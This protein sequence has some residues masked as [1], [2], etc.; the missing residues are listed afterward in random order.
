MKKSVGLPRMHKE[1]G[2]RR[3]F[4][5][6]FVRNLLERGHPVLIERGLGTGMGLS[7]ADYTS[8]SPLLRLGDR[9]DAFAQDVVLVLRTPE[10][11]E[12]D[13]L[14]RPGSV[15]VSMLHFGTRPR[16]IRKLKEL[17]VDAVS[18]DSLAD[19][20]GRRLVENTRAVG[21]NG[22]EAAFDALERFSPEVLTAGQ[23]P[24]RVTVMGA[25][26][27]GKNAVEAAIK[28]GSPSRARQWADRGVR[29]VEVTAIG[30]TLTRDPRY[31]QE[32][33]STTDVL[34]D[35]TQRSDAS[36]PL[37]PNGWIG[38][39]PKHAV[40]CD[41]V[42][43]PYVPSGNPPTVRSMEG[44]PRGDLDQW[45]FAPDDENW[46]ASIPDGV[47]T[48]HRRATVTCYSWP[49]IHPEECMRHYGVQLWPLMERLL[50]RGGVDALSPKGDLLDRALCRASVRSWGLD[51]RPLPG[52][53]QNTMLEND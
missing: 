37:V 23:G 22:L 26:L 41:L 50:D 14:L 28:Y 40:L 6:D 53:D 38:F 51:A 18:L 44:I 35:A 3:D 19:D 52:A 24:L 43:D 4:L 16:R 8:L 49:G 13:A 25:G 46:S 39:L 21:W 5:P 33:F 30:R 15:L 1:E 11:E 32:R 2:E 36:K 27:V 48:Q 12:Y 31:L 34:V 20:E 47:P 45:I 17:G 9:K 29:P 10:V 42:V 7:D